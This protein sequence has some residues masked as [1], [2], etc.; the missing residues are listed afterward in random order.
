MDLPSCDVFGLPYSGEPPE[1]LRYRLIPLSDTAA[2]EALMRNAA[3]SRPRNQWFWIRFVDER[4]RTERGVALSD[5]AT[6]AEALE[7]LASHVTL[8]DAEPE[9][10]PY[11]ADPPEH[12]R[13]RMLSQDEIQEFAGGFAPSGIGGWANAIVG[14]VMEHDISTLPNASVLENLL[15]RINKLRKDR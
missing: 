2:I 13:Y 14:K 4:D 11:P 8:P 1:E 3:A 15:D 10:Y 5:G 6:F 9:G 12:L 7:R